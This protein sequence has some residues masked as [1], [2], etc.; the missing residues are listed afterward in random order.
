M[1][2]ILIILNHQPTPEQLAQLRNMGYTKHYFVQHPLI[3]PNASQ[4]EVDVLFKNFEYQCSEKF[5][6]ALVDALW[7]QGDFRFFLSAYK[8]AKSQKIPLFIAT[9]QRQAVEKTMPDGSVVK[10]SVFKH[11]TFIEVTKSH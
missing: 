4:G 8:F 3:N 11:I 6:Y 9:T 1:A 10:T 5:N 2:K 7:V